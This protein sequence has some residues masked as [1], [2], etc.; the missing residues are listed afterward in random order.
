MIIETPMRN[1]WYRTDSNEDETYDDIWHT[2][3]RHSGSNNL[4]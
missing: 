2:S 3:P 1:K 4:L